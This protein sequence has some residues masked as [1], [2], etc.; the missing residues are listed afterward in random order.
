MHKTFCLLFVC[1]A[2]ALAQPIGLGLKVGLPLTDAFNTSSNQT[3]S[4]SSDTKRFIIGPQLELRFP[5]GI[6][7]EVDA[8]FTRLEYS[9]VGAVAGS[10]ANA[11]TDADSRSRKWRAGSL[12]VMESA[13]RNATR[14]HPESQRSR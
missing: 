6:G 7:I 5:A 2:A 12:D 9:S 4:Y 10:V 1:A 11:A 3:T 8:L 13:R 14:V